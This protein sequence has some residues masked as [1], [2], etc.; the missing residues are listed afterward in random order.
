MRVTPESL[1]LTVIFVFV[2]VEID[3]TTCG[4]VELDLEGFQGSIR[5]E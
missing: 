1:C 4:E 2:M 5:L 3:D